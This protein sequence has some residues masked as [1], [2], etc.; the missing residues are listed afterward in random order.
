[1]NAEEKL[2][3]ELSQNETVIQVIP[4]DELQQEA[5]ARNATV[6]T[7]AGFVAPINDTILAAK[8]L[9]EFGQAPS[10]LVVNTYKGKKYV[11]FK[12][13][14]G[15]RKIFRG[16]RYL[17]SNPTVVRMAVGPRGIAKSVK[18]G[19]VLTVVL[20]AGIEIFD[21]VIK[22]T[23]NLSKLLGTITADVMKVGVSS[24]AALA[25][26]LA[27]GASTALGSIV[28][29]PLIAAIAVGVI[30]GFVLDKID[31]RIGATAALIKAY[32]DT[33]LKLR[34]VEYDAARWLDYFERNPHAIRRL[35]G[36]PSIFTGGY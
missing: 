19:F 3:Q 11:I 8:L 12:G 21:Y 23:K 14:S 1:M 7:T 25:A 4:L 28:A 16:T 5:S 22:D 29:G 9:R 36:M 24:I 20:L 27:I 26:G 30:T 32:E 13:Q 31:S 10:Q 6:K 34:E 35:F 15:T 18:G 2:V 17:T 33:G